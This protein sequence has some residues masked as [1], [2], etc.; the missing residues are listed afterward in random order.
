MPPIRRTTG[1]NAPVRRPRVAG[2]SARTDRAATSTVD[3]VPPTATVPAPPESPVTTVAQD[4]PDT[5]KESRSLGKPETR[6]TRSTPEVSE[7]AVPE[8]APRARGVRLGWPLVAVLGA[9]AVLLAGFASLAYL[10]PG[11]QVSNTAYVDIAATSEVTDATRTAL[12]TLYAYK[13][14]TIGEYPER[15][16]GV[17]TESMRAEFDKTVEPT[18]SAVEQSGTSTTV[19][20]S[21]IGVKLL[22]GDRAELIVNMTVSAESNGVAQD[23]ASGPLIVQMEKVDGVW[24]LSGIADQ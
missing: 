21:D 16:R 11:A 9:T 10:R 19:A 23:S 18:V 5:P 1:A 3:E 4:P 8:A 15:A 7:S 13:R 24:L 6:E 2:T 14:D 17:L 20:L 22:D 12:T